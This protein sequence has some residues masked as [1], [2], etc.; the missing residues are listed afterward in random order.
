MKLHSFQATYST[1]R[2]TGNIELG[3]YNALE[4]WFQKIKGEVPKYDE[5]F[6]KGAEEIGMFFREVNK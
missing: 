6:D 2:A 4:Q 1:I 3:D 5:L